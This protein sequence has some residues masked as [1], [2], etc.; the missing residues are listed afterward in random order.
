MMLNF[1]MPQRNQFFQLNMNVINITWDLQELCT[2][3][4]KKMS[5]GL[6][7]AFLKVVKVHGVNLLYKKL[8]S[9]W[10]KWWNIG[11]SNSSVIARGTTCYL[12]WRRNELSLVTFYT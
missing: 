12:F 11:H 5:M 1:E 2:V 6:Y 9:V 10:K 4:K 8:F 7:I 3:Q